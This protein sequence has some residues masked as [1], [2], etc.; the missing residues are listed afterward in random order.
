MAT[1]RVTFERVGRCHAVPETSIE[2]ATIDDLADEL[3]KVAQRYCRSECIDVV[4]DIGDTEGEGHFV[5]GL[6]RPAGDFTFSVTGTFAD[7]EDEHAE[8]KA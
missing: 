7:G 3:L 4:L 8:V 5:V 1:C 2:A 6:M